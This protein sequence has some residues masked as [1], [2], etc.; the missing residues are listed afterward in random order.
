MAEQPASANPGGGEG[1]RDSSRV[2]LEEEPLVT[3]PIQPA[4]RIADF[5]CAR[6]ER[7]ERFFHVEMPRYTRQSYCRVFILPNPQDATEIW[8]YYTL[9]PSN[10]RPE[11]LRES[12]TLIRR[13]PGSI[14]VPTMLIGFMGRDDRVPKDRE[15]GKA[16]LVDAALRVYRSED[17]TAWALTLDSER[18]PGTRLFEWYKGMGFKARTDEA[19]NEMGTMY[20]PIRSLVPQLPK[21]MVTDAPKKTIP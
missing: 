13:L 1:G 4:H 15:L 9:T 19:G 6:S 17:A 18:G 2:A 10:L 3:F 5:R 14:P 11:D 8:G 12:R 21:V 20:C 16:L 7:V